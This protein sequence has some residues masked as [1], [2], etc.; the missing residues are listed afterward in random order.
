MPFYGTGGI[1]AARN[2]QALKAAGVSHVVNASPIVPC[3]HR[4]RL[5]Y[6]VVSVYDDEAEDITQHFPATNRYIAKV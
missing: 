5:H 4:G 3:F 2:L 1:A 6:R